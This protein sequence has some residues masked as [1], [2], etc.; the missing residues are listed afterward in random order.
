MWDRRLV[1]IVDNAS[2][3]CESG[4]DVNHVLIVAL[5]SADAPVNVA[6]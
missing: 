4:H 5:G 3:R 1:E 2:E 6:L